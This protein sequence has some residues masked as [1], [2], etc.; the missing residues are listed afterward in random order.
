M[1]L[2]EFMHNDFCGLKSWELI[3]LLSHKTQ[4]Y[5]LVEDFE[6]GCHLRIERFERGRAVV[7]ACVLRKQANESMNDLF[8]DC[9]FVKTVWF[10]GE[11]N[12]H[13]DRQI[14]D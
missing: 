14:G 2:L 8:L 11:H 5:S 13:I 6:Q 7:P 1:I 4:S 9:H 10:E 12:C 3:L